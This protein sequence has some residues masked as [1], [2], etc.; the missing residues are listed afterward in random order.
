MSSDSDRIVVDGKS[1][2]TVPSRSSSNWGFLA[3]GFALGLG[4][5]LLVS[6][7]VGQTPEEPSELGSASDGTTTTIATPLSAGIAETIPGFPDGLNVLISPG[8]GRALEVLTWPRDGAAVYRSIALGDLDL[9]GTPSFDSSG[10]FLAA[11]T[12]SLDAV[13]LHAGRTNN[14]SVVAPS[15]TGFTWHDSMAGRLA[16]SVRDGESLQ[17]WLSD[18]GSNPEPLLSGIVQGES[19]SA[20]GDWGVAIGLGGSTVEDVTHLY[21]L[22]GDEIATIAGRVIAS[23]PSGF[24]LVEEATGGAAR[25]VRVDVSIGVVEDVGALD[26]SE[27]R[28]GVP[29]GGSFSPDADMVAISGFAAVAVYQIGSDDPPQVYPIRAGSVAVRWSSDGAYL[30][31]SGF[32]GVAVIEIATGEITSILELETTRTVS[33]T[34]I[35]S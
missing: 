34:P 17:V 24:L 18:A 25:V 11:V 32:R 3:I 4:L 29:I 6:N 9:A 10:Q 8:Q 22:S 16:W 12:S 14:F 20:L 33:P 26:T 21:S 28:G 23:H 7:S 27:L 19:V 1:A 15:V 2:S 35:G 13:D 5:A 30:L 31:V